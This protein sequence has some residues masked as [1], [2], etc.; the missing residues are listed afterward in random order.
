MNYWMLKGVEINVIGLSWS[1]DALAW[2][3]LSK[4]QHLKLFRNGSLLQAEWLIVIYDQ[5]IFT[6]NLLRQPGQRNSFRKFLT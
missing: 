1:K 3:M 6:L 2:A 4:K 5:L